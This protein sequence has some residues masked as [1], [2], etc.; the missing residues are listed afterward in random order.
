MSANHFTWQQ[1]KAIRTRN[2]VARLRENTIYERYFLRGEHLENLAKEL[3]Y[4]SISSIEK[5]V[6]RVRKIYNLPTK[7]E[8]TGEALDNPLIAYNNSNEEVYLF[9]TNVQIE[10]IGFK[11]A[12]ALYSLVNQ[13]FTKITRRKN[14][15][16]WYFILAKDYK[17]QGHESR[18]L[19]QQVAKIKMDWINK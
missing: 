10:K 14:A 18:E 9:Y 7:R 19:R 1:T 15:P 11:K 6:A 8:M 12:N 13:T 5:A 17:C 4:K 2:A 16:K 3:G